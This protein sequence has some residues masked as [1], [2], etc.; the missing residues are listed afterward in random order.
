MKCECERQT[1]VVRVYLGERAKERRR[2]KGRKR[3]RGKDKGK[4][5]KMELLK[6]YIIL[7]LIQFGPTSPCPPSPLSFRHRFVVRPG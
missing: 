3:Q 7:P 1:E 6:S 4:N 5:Q 2:K